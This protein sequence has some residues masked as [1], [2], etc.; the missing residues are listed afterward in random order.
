[1]PGTAAVADRGD[2][3][4]RLLLYISVPLA[5]VAVLAAPAAVWW[6]WDSARQPKL[7]SDLPAMDEAIT[8]TV[9]AAGPTVPLAISGVFQGAVCDFGPLRD[10]VRFTRSVDLYTDPRSET[11]LIDGSPPGYPPPTNHAGASPPA[12]LR[13]P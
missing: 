2:R 7:D 1:M 9:T 11:A 12:P 3:R 13:R 6:R 8:A 10:G 5:V 4:V